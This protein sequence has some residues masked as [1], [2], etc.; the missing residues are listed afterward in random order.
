[1]EYIKR[2]GHDVETAKNGREAL[3]MF[4]PDVHDLVVT[5]QGMPGLTGQQMA[6]AITHRNADTPVILLTGFGEMSNAPGSRPEGVDLVLQKPV[7][8]EGLKRAIVG[9]LTGSA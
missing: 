8:L 5:D 4:D 6:V 7:T 9:V 3:D 2:A 1:V